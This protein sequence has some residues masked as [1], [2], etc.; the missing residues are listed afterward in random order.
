MTT[1]ENPTTYYS[2]VIEDLPECLSSKTLQPKI[3]QR[4]PD[5]HYINQK[6]GQPLLQIYDAQKHG[7]IEDCVIN[8]WTTPLPIY[9]QLDA[10]SRHII[11]TIKSYI[12][13]TTVAIS[14][15][16][17]LQDKN[18]QCHSIHLHLMVEQTKAQHVCNNYDFK[19]LQTSLKPSIKILTQKV[20]V[21]PAFAGY[22]MNEP[23]HYLGTNSHNIKMLITDSQMYQKEKQQL[24]LQLPPSRPTTTLNILRSTGHNKNKEAKNVP[25]Y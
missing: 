18:C 14:H 6:S 3:H 15:H 9:T 10:T 12:N 24:Q 25:G 22:L 2:I 23:K 21:P 8:L 7:N 4:T 20:R 17:G 1:E 16:D 19:K 11:N 13:N 5:G